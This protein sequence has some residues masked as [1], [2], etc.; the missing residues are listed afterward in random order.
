MLK[1]TR[2]RRSDRNQVIYFIRHVDTGM[3]YIGL[4][5]LSF[6]G[7]VKKTLHRRMQKHLQR[8]MAEDKNWSISLALRKFG[9]EAFVYGVLEVVRGKKSAHI[10]ETELINTLQP[11]LNTFGIK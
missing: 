5:A 10:R 3:E 2:K 8:A 1:N 7:S 4:T 6:N 9:P 11:C